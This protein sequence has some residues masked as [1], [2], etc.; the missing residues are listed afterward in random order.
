[1]EKE[2]GYVGNMTPQQEKVLEI[3][4]HHISASYKT[5]RPF[6]DSFLLRFCRA[7]E[8]DIQKVILMF[9]AMVQWRAMCGVDEMHVE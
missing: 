1:M 5:P 7:R 8:F 6:D 9:D 3:L 4:K 2:A